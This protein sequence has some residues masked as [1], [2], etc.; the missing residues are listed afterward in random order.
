MHMY[1]PLDFPYEK[2]GFEAP[3][4]YRFVDICSFEG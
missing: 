3:T 4:N 1:P 2:G